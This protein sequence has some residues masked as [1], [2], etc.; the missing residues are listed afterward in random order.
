M[1]LVVLETVHTSIQDGC[2]RDICIRDGMKTVGTKMQ[3][4]PSTERA[5]IET[6]G[7][8]LTGEM[9]CL[10]LRQLGLVLRDIPGGVITT[11]TS[12]Q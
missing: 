2:I 12:C 7:A 6:A 3:R 9:A 4:L 8:V 1:R 5:G 10:L 11:A